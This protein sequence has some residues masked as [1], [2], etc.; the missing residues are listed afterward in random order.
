MPCHR[1][2]IV[3]APLSIMVSHVACLLRAGAERQ[4]PGQ[5]RLPLPETECL[6]EML[7]AQAVRHGH[8]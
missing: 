8:R 3:V 2:Q 7:N 4:P 5:A 6:I 1:S